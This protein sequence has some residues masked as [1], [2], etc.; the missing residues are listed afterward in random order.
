[1]KDFLL[2]CIAGAVAFG[3]PLLIDAIRMG[4]L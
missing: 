3:I 2:G 1:M 4:V